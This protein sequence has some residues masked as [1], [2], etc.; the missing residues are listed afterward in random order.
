MIVSSG[1][2][3]TPKYWVRPMLPRK[4]VPIRIAITINVVW[5]FLT[6]GGLKAGTPFPIASMPVSAVQ[7]EARACSTRKVVTGSWA[8]GAV[9]S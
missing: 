9:S 5:A 7:P 8:G 4:S 1:P 2:A 3:T 6:S